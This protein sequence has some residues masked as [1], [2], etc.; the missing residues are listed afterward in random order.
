M[1]P[2]HFFYAPP[3]APARPLRARPRDVRPYDLSHIT[4]AHA[5]P[6]T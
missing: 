2:R 4:W 6:D 1:T 3:A 5:F